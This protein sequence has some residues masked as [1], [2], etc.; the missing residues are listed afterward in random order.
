MNTETGV[1]PTE[2][3]PLGKVAKSRYTDFIQTDLLKASDNP[4]Q[5]YT[6]SY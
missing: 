5:S 1:S 4:P 3:L 6:V 2:W